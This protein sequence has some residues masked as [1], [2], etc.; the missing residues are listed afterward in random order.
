MLWHMNSV[1]FHRGRDF[2]KGIPVLFVVLLVALFASALDERLTL[3]PRVVLI[4]A[5]IALIVHFIH[6]VVTL[7]S[8][9]KRNGRSK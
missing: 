1:D 2:E 3:L 5:M 4:G 7:V 9:R 6:H 8:D